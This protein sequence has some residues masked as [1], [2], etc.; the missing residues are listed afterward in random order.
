M[1]EDPGQRLSALIEQF[2]S[3]NWPVSRL[4]TCRNNERSAMH[5]VRQ[6]EH[7]LQHERKTNLLVEDLVSLVD[8]CDVAVV[9]VVPLS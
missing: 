8:V 2:L 7:A 9:L 1:F 6:Y 3:R 4:C 5:K